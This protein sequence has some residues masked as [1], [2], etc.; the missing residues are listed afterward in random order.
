MTK[1]GRKFAAGGKIAVGGLGAVLVTADA[2]GRVVVG[3]ARKDGKLIAS[4][5]TEG[6]HRAKAAWHVIEEGFDDWST[7]DH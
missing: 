2:V 4:A 6:V 7:A 1:A 5:V 3:V